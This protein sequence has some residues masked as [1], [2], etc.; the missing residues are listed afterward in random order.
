MNWIIH[1]D[2][3][4]LSCGWQFREKSL[5]V[6]RGFGIVLFRQPQYLDSP[7][8]RALVRWSNWI[9]YRG[10]SGRNASPET[11]VRFRA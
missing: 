6:K 5:K 8:R 10:E 1:K 11:P 4:S 3:T 2:C 7:E 9:A